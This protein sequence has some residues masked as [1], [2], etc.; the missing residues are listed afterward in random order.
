M[1]CDSFFKNVCIDPVGTLTDAAH[2]H[3]VVSRENSFEVSIVPSS[4]MISRD[5]LSDVETPGTQ[6]GSL[7][8]M[9]LQI[10]SGS[11]SCHH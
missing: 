10:L 9:T 5:D 8:T 11:M 1:C 3:E 6:K 4:F 7:L 2:M